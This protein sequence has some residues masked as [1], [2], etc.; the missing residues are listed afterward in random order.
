MTRRVGPERHE[1]GDR[2]MNGHPYKHT[3]QVSDWVV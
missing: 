1:K 2:M 3:K